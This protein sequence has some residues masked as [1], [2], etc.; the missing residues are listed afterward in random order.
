MELMHRQVGAVVEHK[1]FLIAIA[2]ASAVFV[3][4]LVVKNVEARNQ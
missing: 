3:A 2:S 4:V 1:R